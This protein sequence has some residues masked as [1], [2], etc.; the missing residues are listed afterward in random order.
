MSIIVLFL[1]NVYVIFQLWAVSIRKTVSA[2]TVFAFFGLGISCVLFSV[3]LCHFLSTRFIP[4]KI[5][6][7][8]A[9]PVIEELLKLLPVIFFILR[10]PARRKLGILDIMLLAVAL[11]TGF[12]VGESA[13]RLL[14][15][16]DELRHFIPLGFWKSMFHWMLQWHKSSD[17]FQFGSYRS[18]FRCARQVQF[19]GH[20][21]SAAIA[22]IGLGFANLLYRGRGRAKLILIVPVFL[23]LWAIFDHAAYNYSIGYGPRLAPPFG[24]LYYLSG[25]GTRLASCLTLL[26]IVAIVIEELIVRRQLRDEIGIRLPGEESLN[27]S[28]FSELKLLK[29]SIINKDGRAFSLCKIFAMRRQLAYLKHHDI[30]KEPLAE[31]LRSKIKGEIEYL[32]YGR[33]PGKK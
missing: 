13:L 33:D 26:M 29:N 9:N 23:G 24:F 14:G 12:Q 31:P 4:A 1:V 21:I 3:F 27:P 15:G 16:R 25:A 18:L 28:F 8:T 7:Y 20:G 11:G 5:N 32:A 30:E 6:V 17:Y 10:Y 19:A 2:K 22:G